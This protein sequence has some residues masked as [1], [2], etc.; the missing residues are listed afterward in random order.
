MA[1]ELETYRR[2]GNRVKM[3]IGASIVVQAGAL[4]AGAA[5]YIA[6]SNVHRRQREALFVGILTP[7]IKH[8]TTELARQL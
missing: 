3:F 1:P 4:Q 5:G 7:S 8:I 2:L 6:G